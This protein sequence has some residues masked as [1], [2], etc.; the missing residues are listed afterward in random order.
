MKATFSRDSCTLG[1]YVLSLTVKDDLGASNTY[2]WTINVK[3]TSSFLPQMVV[4]DKVVKEVKKEIKLW[5][6]PEK[7][8]V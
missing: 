3:N 1:S 6:P 5:K 7:D 8:T 2:K 4:E